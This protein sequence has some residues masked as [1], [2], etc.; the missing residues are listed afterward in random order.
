MYHSLKV[1]KRAKEEFE[2]VFRGKEL[3]SKIPG[4]KIKEKVLN[5]LDLL[6]KAKIALSKSEAKRLILQGGVKINGQV[7]TEW[8]RV[9][10]IKKGLVVQ[11]GK[12]KF[13]KII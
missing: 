5:A 9:V 7:L 10:K 6:V 12:R 11:V 13:A 4:I 8:Q 1:A 2:K 3:P